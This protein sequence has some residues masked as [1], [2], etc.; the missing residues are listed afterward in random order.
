MKWQVSKINLKEV[1]VLK[2][3]KI[4]FMMSNFGIFLF[5]DC[6]FG[7]SEDLSLKDDHYRCNY[8][9]NYCFIILHSD[10]PVPA[11][12]AIGVPTA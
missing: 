12:R 9:V 10:R 2:E 6:S 4:F 5:D 11:S 7:N 1:E 3:I 8:N